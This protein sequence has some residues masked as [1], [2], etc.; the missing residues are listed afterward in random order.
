MTPG[1]LTALLL[2][3]VAILVV[4]FVVFVDTVPPRSATD[5]TMHVMKR[6][7]LRYARINGSLPMSLD[8]LPR[9][10]GYMNEVTDGWAR[11]VLWRAESDEVALTSYGRDGVPG[12]TGDDADMVGVFRTR[13]VD[14]RWADELCDWQV[15]PFATGKE[16]KAEPSAGPGPATHQGWKQ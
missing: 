7:M 14:G 13:A 12:G 6:R 5:V 3:M 1:R 11:P 15:D 10:E 4:V 16:P 8:R 9:I 2:G